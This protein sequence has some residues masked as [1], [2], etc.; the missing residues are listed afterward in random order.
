M[1]EEYP[2][3]DI[4]EK[5][6][7]AAIEVHRELGPGYLESIY[8]QALAKEFDSRKIKYERQKEIGIFYKDEQVGKHRLDFIVEGKVVLEIKSVERF[9]EVHRAQV[10]SYCKASDLKVGLLINFNMAVLKKGIKRIVY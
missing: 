4:T 8:E 9:D 6:I 5:V 10:I 3:S 1:K 7:S 2:H